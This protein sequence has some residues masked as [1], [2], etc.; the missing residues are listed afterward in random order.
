MDTQ[1][2]SVNSRVDTKDSLVNVFFS[3]S[4]ST[5]L[6]CQYKQQQTDLREKSNLEK[7]KA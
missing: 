5:A 3:P 6:E 2:P 4:D 1:C 7:L